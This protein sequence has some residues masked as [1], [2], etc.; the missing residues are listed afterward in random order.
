ML[1]ANISLYPIQQEHYNLIALIEEAE[2]LL[3]PELEEA[4]QLTQHQF[5]RQ[6]ISY[7]FVVKAF[8]DTKEV[9]D[10]EIKRLSEL[11]AKAVKRKELFK[12]RLDA[13]M[14]QFGVEKITTETLSLSY[15]K[16]ESVEVDEENLADE[17]MN[18]KITYTP[19]KARIKAA[20]KEGESVP[21][22]SI[23]VKQNL[24]IK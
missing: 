16:S 21:G 23:V 12:E 6:A 7:G 10:K 1:P 14:K 5:E 22:A 15:R 11:G 3:T 19:D 18:E 8:D 9:I 4:L 24:Q 20:I 2:G 13:A 17:W